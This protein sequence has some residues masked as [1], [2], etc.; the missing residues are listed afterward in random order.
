M[1]R[2]AASRRGQRKRKRVKVY[3][4][5]GVSPLI[6]DPSRCRGL[7]VVACLGIV[8]DLAVVE[9]QGG[10]DREGGGGG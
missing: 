6:A 9:S 10:I 8:N 2:D 4:L 3:K 7:S 5:N 1:F